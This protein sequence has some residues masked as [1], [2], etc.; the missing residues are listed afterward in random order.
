MWVVLVTTKSGLVSCSPVKGLLSR[1][2]RAQ[3]EEELRASELGDCIA[4]PE[5]GLAACNGGVRRVCV[6]QSV[7]CRS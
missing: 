2:R 7:A 1:V 5:V 6:P 3:E 4:S